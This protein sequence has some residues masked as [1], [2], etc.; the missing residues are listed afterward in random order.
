MVLTRG[1]L[2]SWIRAQNLP[3]VPKISLPENL[4]EKWGSIRKIG[5][6]AGEMGKGLRKHCKSGEINKKKGLA[7]HHSSA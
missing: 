1:R 6:I 4:P 5:E 3:L 2:K 7:S